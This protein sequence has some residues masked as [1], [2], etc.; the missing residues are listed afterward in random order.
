MYRRPAFFSSKMRDT[1]FDLSFSAKKMP[2]EQKRSVGANHPR[3]SI[4]LSP[5]PIVNSY[6]G[7]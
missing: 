1:I 5:V 2:K 4:I 3:A 6:D 7:F